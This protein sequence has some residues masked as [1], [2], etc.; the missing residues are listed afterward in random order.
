[1]G[2][3]KII[4]MRDVETERVQFLWNPYIPSGKISIASVYFR[5][6]RFPV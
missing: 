2:E 5:G 1:M 3:L 6:V 4:T